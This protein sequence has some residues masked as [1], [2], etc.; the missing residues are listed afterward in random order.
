MTT[1]VDND[2]QLAPRRARGNAHRV[3]LLV[4]YAALAAAAALLTAGF[5]AVGLLAGAVVVVV[6]A[7]LWVLALWRGWRWLIA[8]AWGAMTFTAAVS[9]FAGVASLF[10]VG[11]ITAA[12]LSWEVRRFD[13]FLASAARVEGEAALARQY[14]LRL[15]V[16]L[17][18]GVALAALPGLLQIDFGF[19]VALPLACLSVLGFSFAISFL[20]RQSD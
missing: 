2:A 8:L 10:A 3:R 19:A 13:I 1:F 4:I 6:L 17:V 5:L 18:L 20:R 9:L 14:W 7:L 16:V 12:L 11:S 15:V